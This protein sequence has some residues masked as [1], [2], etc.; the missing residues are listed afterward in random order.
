MAPVTAFTVNVERANAFHDGSPM[1]NVTGAFARAGQR[2]V[3]VRHSGTCCS[4]RRQSASIPSG[5][6]CS[7][8]ERSLRPAAGEPAG[9]ASRLRATGTGLPLA[10]Y[11]RLVAHAYDMITPVAV[12]TIK[13]G[14]HQKPMTLCQL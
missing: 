11:S 14:A 8:P 5:I 4:A 7:L 2:I 9:P 6:R 12:S 1:E 13:I 10:R 3:I